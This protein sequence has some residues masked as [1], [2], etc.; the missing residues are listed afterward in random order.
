MDTSERLHSKVIE[1]ARAEIHS[2]LLGD[3]EAK[4]HY[5]QLLRALVGYVHCEIITQAEAE[6]L[7]NEAETALKDAL[8]R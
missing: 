2:I 8:R 6:D 1:Y 7:Q 4:S 3:G 5:N